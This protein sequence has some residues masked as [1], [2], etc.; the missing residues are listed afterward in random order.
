MEG[1]KEEYI[2][3]GTC[4]YKI[5]QQPLA[6]GALALSDRIMVR[7]IRHLF[8]NMTV[9]V[10][11]PAIPIIIKRLAVSTICMSPLTTYHQK[12]SFQTL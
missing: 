8:G 10:L 3:V 11:F 7:T 9:S 1:N 12:E 4:L 5:A 2:R 6:N